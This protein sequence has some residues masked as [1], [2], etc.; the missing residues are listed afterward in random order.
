MLCDI[1]LTSAGGATV[2][3]RFYSAAH[4]R[5]SAGTQFVTG[6]RWEARAPGSAS[7]SLGNSS[8]EAQR[9]AVSIESETLHMD[10]RLIRH[11]P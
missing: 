8:H 6:R 9:S 10:S 2:V 3:G 4:W 1:G 7:S 5:T 11:Q